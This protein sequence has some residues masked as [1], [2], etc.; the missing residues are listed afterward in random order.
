[1]AHSS[2][3]LRTEQS[4][5]LCRRLT[6]K[7]GKTYYLATA[8][9]PKHKRRYVHAL[10]GL[11]RMADDIVDDGGVPAP[12]RKAAIS[13]FRDDFMVALSLNRRSDLRFAA[14]VDTV[15]RWDIEPALFGDFFDAMAADLTTHRYATYADLR[16]YM[17]GSAMVIAEQ[18]LPI[19]EPSSPQAAPGAVALGEAFQLANFLRD[20]GE[21]L[22][23]DRIYLPLEDLA[24]F[25]LDETD[26][27]ARVVTDGFRAV[28]DQEIA[29]VHALTTRARKAIGLLHPAVQPAIAAAADLYSGIADQVAE[30]DYQVFTHRAR[31]PRRTRLAVAA[32]AWRQARAAQRQ[33]GPG[34]D[35]DCHRGGPA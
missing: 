32:R 10:Y 33:S 31:V 12:Q 14:T 17:H 7:H 35:P 20:V 16:G 15:C 11:A 25:G 5:E 27:Q 9:F 4:Y 26:V 2:S 28:M 22:D 30:I 34:S 1:M 6:A 19:L 8:L 21:D 13:R 29:R 23:R 24:R 3:D 18:M